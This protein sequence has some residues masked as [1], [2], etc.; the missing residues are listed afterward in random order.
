MTSHGT[1][2]RYVWLN[3]YLKKNRHTTYIQLR[4]LVWH[5][6]PSS[7]VQSRPM[8]SLV[9]LPFGRYRP[10]P[11]H[12][13]LL[14]PRPHLPAERQR[15]RRMFGWQNQQLGIFTRRSSRNWS[16]VNFN[17]MLLPKVMQLKLIIYRLYLVPWC[18]DL[19]F[20]KPGPVATSNDPF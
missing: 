20:T 15:Q 11:R 3:V 17:W 1:W 16:Q 6:H 13:S 14:H 7:R 19:G 18:H 5:M 9:Q 12:R 4:K 8:I 10:L 2:C